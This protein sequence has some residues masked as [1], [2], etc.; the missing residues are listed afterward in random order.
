MSGNS[1]ALVLKQRRAGSDLSFPLGSLP[2]LLSQQLSSS[3]TPSLSSLWCNPAAVDSLGSNLELLLSTTER[4]RLK[5]YI[6]SHDRE[7]EDLDDSRST[8]TSFNSFNED[9]ID[10]V[11]DLDLLN[12]SWSQRRSYKAMLVG[13]SHPSFLVLHLLP[14]RRIPF[15]SAASVDGR[16]NFPKESKVKRST[17]NTEWVGMDNPVESE[18][19]E[20]QEV[21]ERMGGKAQ[22]MRERLDATDWS[23]TA[24]GPV[25]K[26]IQLTITY[27]PSLISETFL[28]FAQRESWPL[29]LSTLVDQVVLKMTQLSVI[30]EFSSSLLKLPCERYT[31]DLS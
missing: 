25:S 11:M 4:R 12:P 2:G 19:E 20:E 15:P 13:S 22:T 31:H 5:R 26:N 8:T 24:L 16:G 23:K 21:G 6:I 3:S 14:T 17:L 28:L 29:A 30:C 10:S 1:A 27:K 18:V 7:L 9:S